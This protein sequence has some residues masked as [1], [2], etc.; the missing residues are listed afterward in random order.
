MLR[1]QL[2]LSNRLDTAIQAMTARR[3][4]AAKST[5]H[6][7]EFEE[8]LGNHLREIVQGGGDILQETGSSTGLKPNCKVG[9]YVITI[10][11]E[12]VAAGARIVIEAKESAS[13]DLARTL[14]EAA[15]ARANRQADTCMFV[16]STRTAP[17]SIPTFQRYGRDLVVRWNPDDDE[18]DVWLQAALMVASALSVKAASH[19]KEDAACFEKIDRAIERVRKALDGFDEVNT[20]ANTIKSAAEKILTRARI[21]QEALSSQVEAV[22]NEIVKLKTSAAKE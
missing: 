1:H 11:P 17:A 22:V 4:E 20:S 3:E 14:D 6:G 15:T 5:R 19:D 18:N 7:F 8:T 9:D 16:H 10:G 21:M 2:E 13:Y 12:K